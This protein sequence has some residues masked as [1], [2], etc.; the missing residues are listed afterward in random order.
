MWSEYTKL[1]HQ[2]F[3]TKIQQEIGYQQPANYKPQQKEMLHQHY[4]IFKSN[5]LK[6]QYFFPYSMRLKHTHTHTHTHIYIYSSHLAQEYNAS[7]KMVTLVSFDWFLLTPIIWPRLSNF[8]YLNSTEDSSKDTNNMAQALKFQTF[9][10]YGRFLKNLSQKGKIYYTFVTI[11][12]T[13]FICHCSSVTVH[14]ILFITLFTQ[15]FAYLRR[16]VPYVLLRFFLW[17][18][19]KNFLLELFSFQ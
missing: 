3:K 15:N 2:R 7:E 14:L 17:F 4:N 6:A 8:R 1:K 12:L 18:C 9:E 13:L 5:W 11:H 19:L 16:V 10:L